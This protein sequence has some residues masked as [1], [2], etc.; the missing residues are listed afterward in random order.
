M[1]GMGESPLNNL[2][3]AALMKIDRKRATDRRAQRAA[4]ERR[5]RYIESLLHQIETLSGLP[6]D[7]VHDFFQSNERLK[8]ENEQL[9]R[10]ITILSDNH[11]EDGEGAGTAVSSPHRLLETERS[12]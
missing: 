12:E 8:I 4:R 3:S 7:Q 2:E 6:H 1:E 5:Q 9:Q 10:S 11:T